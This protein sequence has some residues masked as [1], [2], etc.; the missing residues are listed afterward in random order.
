MVMAHLHWP[1][2]YISTVYCNSFKGYQVPTYGTHLCIPL[3]PRFSHPF[4][5]H[6]PSYCKHRAGNSLALTTHSV[7]RK[8]FDHFTSKGRGGGRCFWG[9]SIAARLYSKCCLLWSLPVS[10]VTVMDNYWCPSVV[11]LWQMSFLN[12]KFC[13]ITV[14]S[15]FLEV[16]LS[17]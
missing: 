10:M 13:R 7:Q 2:I 12:N 9:C 5:P 15:V 4:Q 16:T 8:I 6:L 1:Y 3:C 17:Q 11:V 14:G